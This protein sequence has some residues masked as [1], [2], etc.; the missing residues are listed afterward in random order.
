MREVGNEI[1]VDVKAAKHVYRPSDSPADFQESLIT[2]SCSWPDF[3]KIEGAEQIIDRAEWS[4]IEVRLRELQ[5]I[6]Q[7]SPRDDRF[8]ICVPCFHS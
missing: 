7:K 5:D 3:K 1:W 4:K 8:R 2:E 6:P